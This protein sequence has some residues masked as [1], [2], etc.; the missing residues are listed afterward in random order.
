MRVRPGRH[1]VAVER[2]FASAVDEGDFALADRINAAN[3]DLHLHDRPSLLHGV[4][5]PAVTV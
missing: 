1:A 2:E 4:R 3:P 5:P